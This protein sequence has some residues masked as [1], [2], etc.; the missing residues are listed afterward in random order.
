MALKKALSLME[1]KMS[2]LGISGSVFPIDLLRIKQNKGKYAGY[3]RQGKEGRIID[4]HPKSYSSAIELAQLGFHELGH[5]YWVNGMTDSQRADWSVLYAKYVDKRVVEKDVLDEVCEA[6][7]D[8]SD[9]MSYAATLEAE[10]LD[11]FNIVVDEICASNNL[12][13]ED[14]T[15]IHSMSRDHIEH[16]MPDFSSK[17]LA[18]TTGFPI[19]D[20]AGKASVEFFAESFRVYCTGKQLPKKIHRLMKLSIGQ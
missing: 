9:L 5:D 10:Q 4:F 18:S 1:S 3:Y 2:D 7:K 15:L 12:T 6:I 13:M 19:S 17:Q 8:T 16:L 11:A 14:L 20:Y